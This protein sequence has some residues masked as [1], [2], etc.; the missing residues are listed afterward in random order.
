MYSTDATKSQTE[1]Q[2]KLRQAARARAR[3]RARIAERQAIRLRA[4]IGGAF[5]AAVTVI[6]WILVGS[7]NLGIA[8]PIIA[9]VLFAAYVAGMIYLAREWRRAED[10]DYAQ[11]ARAERILGPARAAKSGQRKAAGEARRPSATRKSEKPVEKPA[12]ETAKPSVPETEAQPV[13][14]E[15]APAPSPEKAP[16]VEETKRESVKAEV[17]KT[18]LRAVKSDVPSYTLKPEAQVRAASESVRAAQ[19]PIIKRAVKPYEP[20]QEIVTDGV[21]VPYRPVRVGERLGDLDLDAAN[22][23]PSMTG[24]EELSS[25]VLGGGFTLDAVM[26]RRRA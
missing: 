12:Q 10:H 15:S 1:A 18:G 20:E 25:Q 14:A 6:L 16:A 17:R 24:E 11:I 23:A 7:I 4:I 13:V 19:A 5:F 22:D 3:A 2:T 8:I 26:E 9:S 21:A